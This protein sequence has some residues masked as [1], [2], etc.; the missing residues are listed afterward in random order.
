MLK[1]TKDL[2]TI[3]GWYWHKP[4]LTFGKDH[5]PKFY[6]KEVFKWR[7]DMVDKD[8]SPLYRGSWWAGPIPEP[9]VEED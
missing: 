7:G 8:L 2:P 6:I 5:P 4:I 3:D 9:A 1:W